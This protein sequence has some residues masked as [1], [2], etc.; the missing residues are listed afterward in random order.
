MEKELIVTPREIEAIFDPYFQE[1]G[2]LMTD[3]VCKNPLF[4][5][6]F[7][8]RVLRWTEDVVSGAEAIDATDVR[9]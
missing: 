6:V 2:E 3:L 9:H 7:M 8:I 5:E 1:F 4:A